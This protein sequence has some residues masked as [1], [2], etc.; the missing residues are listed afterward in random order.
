MAAGLSS[1]FLTSGFFFKQSV[2]V[3]AACLT[4]SILKN[5]Q[6]TLMHNYN[7]L[8]FRYTYCLGDL[9]SML[10]PIFNLR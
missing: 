3:F 7:I 8:L 10:T 9:T 1:F 2:N 6:N 4:P 5:V